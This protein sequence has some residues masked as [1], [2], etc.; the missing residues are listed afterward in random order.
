MSVNIDR[1]KLEIKRAR[2]PFFWLVFLVVAGII[3]FT[4]IFQ[5]QTFQRP[6]QSYYRVRAAFDSVKGVFPGGNQVR[7][8]G[9]RVGVVTS[10]QL[11]DGKGVLTL[12]LDPKYGLVYRDATARI[13][14]QTP[15]DDMFVDLDPGDPASGVLPKSAIL[16]ASQTV[17]PVDISRVLQTFD[18]STRQQLALLLDGLGRGLSDRGQ[19]LQAAFVALAPFLHGAQRVTY[20]MAVRRHELSQLVSNM[21]VLLAALNRRDQQIASL[22][23]DGH[24]TLGALAAAD[25]PLADMI[26]QFPPTLATL[27]SSMAA[28]RAAEANIDP[29]LTSLHPVAKQ[30]DSGLS[31]LQRFATDAAPA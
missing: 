4:F 17:T 2:V 12:S 30:L 9:V 1:L 20:A 27:R 5:N 18:A 8:A 23:R 24:A 10:E 29:A 16:P 28:V 15:L 19:Q 6:W 31:A 3:A 13:R 21:G 14:P 22:V 26:A 25:R 7:I 11:V